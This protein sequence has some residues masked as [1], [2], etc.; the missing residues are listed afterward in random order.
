VTHVTQRVQGQLPMTVGTSPSEAMAA[1]IAP[2]RLNLG[3]VAAGRWGCS[4]A[5]WG[6]ASTERLQSTSGNGRAQAE[7]CNGGMHQTPIA[8]LDH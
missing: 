3:K 1:A 8:S 2:P 5:R 4:R 7:S 6:R